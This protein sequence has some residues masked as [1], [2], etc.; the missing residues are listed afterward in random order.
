MIKHA[1]IYFVA[2][3]LPGVLGFFAFGVYTHVLT[4]SEYGVYSVGVSVAFMIGSVCF[5]WRRRTRI[6]CP[7]P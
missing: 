1:L 2:F 6:S 4:P 3:A 5:G 7:W